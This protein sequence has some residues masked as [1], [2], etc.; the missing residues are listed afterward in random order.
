MELENIYDTI[1]NVKGHIYKITNNI[2]NKVYIGQTY[3]HIKNHGKYRPAGYLKRF[4]SHISEAIVNTKKKQCTYLN[5][6]IR[7]YGKENFSCILIK[8]CSLSKLDIL[9]Q[10]FIVKYNSL[11]P[12]GYNLTTGGKGAMYVAKVENNSDESNKEIY[13][14]SEETKAKIK[15]RL[16]TIMSTDER[17][18]KKCNE[19]RDQHLKA[20]L[21]KYKD[22]IL[23]NDVSK[24]IRPV[25]KKNT[26]IIYKYEINING[27]ISQFYDSKSSIT[28]LYSYA[29]NF[30]TVLKKQNNIVLGKNE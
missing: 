20:R 26:N 16:S 11:F 2:N 7:K 17:K 24:Y 30:L 21:N 5:N 1:D 27:I 8:E 19:A 4:A 18:A 13:K 14:H 6:A 9:E 29:L 22:I 10:K 15:Q 25:I 12:N 23:D 28:E 3:S